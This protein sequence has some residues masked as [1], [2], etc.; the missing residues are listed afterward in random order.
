LAGRLG[1]RRVPA[2]VEGAA[3]CPLFVC[4]LWRPR[5][6]LPRRLMALLDP[7]QRRQVILHE[8]AHV[9]RRDLAW[10]WPVE[11]ARIVYFFHPL[12]HWVAR[13]LRLERELACDQL[14]MAHSGHPPAEYAQTLVRVVSDASEPAAIQAA[15]IAAELTGGQASK[16]ESRP[17][18]S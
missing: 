8:L 9:K 2:A 5:L 13:Q 4:G 11:I 6:V 3:D 10:G 15:A 12:V 1:L 7:S 16:R 14:A 18:D 17:H